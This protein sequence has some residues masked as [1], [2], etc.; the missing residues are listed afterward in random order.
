MTCDPSGLVLDFFAGSGTTGNA[1]IDLNRGSLED[2]KFILVELGDY[3][4]TVLLPR[5]KKATFTVEWKNGKP[6]RLATPEEA[7]RSPRIV[8]VVRLESYE[9]T[10][11]NLQFRRTEN[12][13]LQL[14]NAEAQAQTD[15]G[16]STRCATC[17]TSR[18]AAAS[19]CSTCRLS[20]TPRP[21]S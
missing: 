16:N 17:S 18:R 12:Q 20:P 8:K 13:R 9:D 11:N 3:F 14:E 1:V 15:S 19:R 4:D 21:T 7:E 2:R 6:K 10:L 5:I